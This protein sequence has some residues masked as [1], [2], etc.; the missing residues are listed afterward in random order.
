MDDFKASLL[1]E[2][3]ILNP[4]NEGEEPIVAL[5]NRISIPLISPDKIDNETFIVRTQN[6]HSCAR[7]AAAVI[8]EFTERGSLINRSKDVPWN[9]L[10]ED[11]VKGYERAWNPNIW[12]AI[13]HNGKIIYQDGEHHPFLDIIEQCDASNLNNYT[14]AIKIAED[15]FAQAGKQ[16]KIEYDSNVALI[17]QIAPDLAKSGIIARSATGTTTFNYT[18]QPKDENAQK[19]HPYTSL[20]VAAA[21]LEAIQLAFQ[22]GFLNQRKEFG[23]IEKYSDEDKKLLRS[24]TRLGNLNRAI[25]N[26]ENKFNVKYRPDRP[27]FNAMKIAAMETAAKT[28]QTEIEERATQGEE[29]PK[30]WVF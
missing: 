16:V 28:L 27:N 20:T 13:Y 21:F 19:L 4:K 2:K 23:L 9:L 1:R 8:K 29:K 12:L 5:S 15:I 10:W 6:M 26:Y 17:S 3:F 11:C 18:T 7:M 22:V 24:V 14:Q 30:D 25:T